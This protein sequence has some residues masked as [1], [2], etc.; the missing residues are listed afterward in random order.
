MNGTD[1]AGVAIAGPAQLPVPVEP[2]RVAVQIAVAPWVTATVPVG[3]PEP[4]ATAATDT[5]KVVDCPYTTLEAGEVEVI[6]VVVDALAITRFWATD[7]DELRLVLVMNCADITLVPAGMVLDV[8]WA[9][10]V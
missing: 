1:D 5:L 3:V 10:A 8:I 6:E 9:V 2:E 7:F 4:G